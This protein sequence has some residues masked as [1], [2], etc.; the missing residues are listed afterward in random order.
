MRRLHLSVWLAVP[1]VS[2]YAQRNKSDP[3]NTYYR[4]YAIVPMVG[5]GTESDPTHPLYAPGVDEV[6]GQANAVVGFTSDLSDDGRYALLEIVARSR[7][8]FKQIL[9]DSSIEKFEKGQASSSTIES[10]FV[11]HKKSFHFSEFNEVA[12]R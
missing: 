1:T 10:A 9:A 6:G 4:I 3:F 12:V 8:A 7:S 2:S 11:K 5:S